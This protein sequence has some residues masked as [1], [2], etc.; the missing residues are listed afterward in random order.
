MWP[1]CTPP[2][3]SPCPGV[4]NFKIEVEVFMEIK[5]H[6]NAFSL[7]PPPH[8]VKVDKIF[9]DQIKYIFT[10][11]PYWPYPRAMHFAIFVEGLMAIITM[12]LFFSN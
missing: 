9:K 8:A 7:C 1:K 6:N 2:P 10:E 4:V 3:L 12:R 11:S 5:N